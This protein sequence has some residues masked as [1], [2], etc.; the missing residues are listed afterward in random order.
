MRSE[1]LREAPGKAAQRASP[2]PKPRLSKGEKANRKRL[3]EVGA[4]YEL[5]PAPRSAAEVLAPTAQKTVAAP[6]AKHKWLT[7]SVID[8]AASVIAEIF[9]EAGAPRPA[10]KRNRV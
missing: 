8:D 6:K 2:R 5:T 7:A 10:P 4:V 3:A 9:D 1:A